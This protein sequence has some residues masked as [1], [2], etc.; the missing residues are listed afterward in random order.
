MY[1]RVW[2]DP[3]VMRYITPEGWPYARE[4]SPDLV[5]KVISFFEEHGFGQW[6]VTLKESGELIGYCGLKIL[7]ATGEVEL[8]YGVGKSYWNRGLVT[9]AAR[10]ALRYGFETAGAEKIVAIALPENV[11]SWRVMEKAGMRRDGTMRHE[12]Y[13]CVR[14]VATRE[15]FEP[16]ADL[17]LLRT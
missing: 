11:G 12:G 3:E 1:D 13:D 15:E 16:G 14:Y 10:A 17:Y 2:S 4:E 5:R 6:A 7:K 8:L 9:E